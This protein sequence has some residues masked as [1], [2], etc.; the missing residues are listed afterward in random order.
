MNQYEKSLVLESADVGDSL[1][2]VYKNGSKVVYTVDVPYEENEYFPHGSIQMTGP[3]C[4]SRIYNV[5][6]PEIDWAVGV[7]SHKRWSVRTL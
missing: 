4:A 7:E 3:L 5:D 6:A 2:F 1:A